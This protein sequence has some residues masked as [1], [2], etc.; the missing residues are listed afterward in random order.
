[1]S[2]RPAAARDPLGAVA[3]PMLGLLVVEFL[4]G[5]GLA[6]FVTLPTG[7]PLTVLAAS[8]LL[9]VHLA[10][11][12]MIIGITARAL[13]D[14]LAAGKGVVR[15]VTA[16]GFVS[17]LLAFLAGLSFTFGDQSAVASFVMSVGFTGVLLDA[18]YLLARRSRPARD[19]GVPPPVRPAAEG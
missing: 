3:A 17:A 5:M 2:A 14:A 6:L 7:S 8:P 13:R 1:M 16:L 4:L 9:W 15:G 18:G 12:L 10:V 11:G 19:E